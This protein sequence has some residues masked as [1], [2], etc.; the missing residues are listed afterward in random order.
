M[1][2]YERKQLEDFLAAI[3]PNLAGYGHSTFSYLVQKKGNV[4]DL[5]Q[6]RLLLQ[7]V[8]APSKSKQFESPSLKVGF[9]RLDE[10]KLTPKQFIENLLSGKLLTPHGELRFLPEKDRNHSIHFNPFHAE[11]VPFQNRHTFQ[12]RQMQ[13]HIR[14]DRRDRLDSSSLDWELKATPTPF[15]SVQE[16]CVEF[17]VGLTDGDSSTVEIVAF[18]VA[19]IGVESSVT[20][21]KAKL[22]I[23]LVNG[24]EREKASLGYRLIERNAVVSRGTLSGKDVSWENTANF[25]RGVARLEVTAGTVLHC[26]ACYG[27]RAQHHYWVADPTTA[28]NPFRA[29]HQAFDSN[30]E[31]LQELISKAESKSTDARDLEIAVAW[32]LWMLGFSATHVG[33]KPKRSDAPDLIATTP[34][35]HFLVIEC[36]TG[37]L[38]ENNKLPHLVARSEKVRQSL[39]ASGN[40]HFKVLPIIVT[41]KTREEVRAESEQ[42]HKLGVLVAT[43][44]VFGELITR[45]LLFPNADQLYAQAEEA[46]QRLQNP[47]PIPALEGLK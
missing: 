1:S 33:A 3:E 43:R 19:A 18:N 41:T 15:E 12:Y 13:L 45:S 9:I 35:G 21:T 32:L 37:I 34:Q 36:T 8:P 17:G 29:V 40:Q 31:I 39:A 4:F 6:G 46:L 38:K 42:A 25:Q 27:G 7:G 28:Q 26:F 24:L 20:G 16:L 47:S 23:N 44:E 30:L 11:G 10:L 2:D 5:A 22:A 14:G